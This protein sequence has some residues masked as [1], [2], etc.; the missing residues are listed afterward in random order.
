MTA[1]LL[2]VKTIDAKHERESEPTTKNA[3]WTTPE[4]IAEVMVLLAG[5]AASTINGARI[6]LYGR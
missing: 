6:Q 3:S 2:I 5:D 1:N 4:E